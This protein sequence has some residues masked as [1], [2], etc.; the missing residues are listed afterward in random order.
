VRFRV[1]FKII[2]NTLVTLRKCIFSREEGRRVRNML[3]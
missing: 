2:P 3:G 1:Q